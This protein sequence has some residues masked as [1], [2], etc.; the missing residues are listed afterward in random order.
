MY[1]GTELKGPPGLE[2]ARFYAD[3]NALK[4]LARSG[5]TDGAQLRQAAEQF[6]SLFINMMFKTMRQANGVFSEGN[7]FESK[8][9]SFYREMLDNQ[10]SVEMARGGGIGLADL[11]VKQLAGR[12]Q[13]QQASDSG[14]HD[15]EIQPLSDAD[16]SASTQDGFG[17]TLDA[18]RIQA[19]QNAWHNNTQPSADVQ[20]QM[21][22]GDDQSL[23]SPYKPSTNARVPLK[24]PSIETNDGLA[25]DTSVPLLPNV[26][27][28]KT[29]FHTPESFVS[30]V[31]PHAQNAGERLGVDPKVLVA[32]AALETGWGKHIMG[33]G[34]GGSSKNLFGIKANEHRAAAVTHNTLEYVDG[35]PQ[36]ERARFRTYE[37]FTESFNDYVSLLENSP[38]YAGARDQAHSPKAFMV[39]L[40]EAGYATDPKY[41]EKIYRIYQGLDEK[42]AAVNESPEQ[43]GRIREAL[44]PSQVIAS[45]DARHIKR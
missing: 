32:Q 33:D 44:L 34:L 26:Q 4:S 17:R 3:Q 22:Y 6:E 11:L 41:A 10:L 37:S 43:L 9:S 45:T 35:K 24:K 27:A 13:G 15:T 7:L 40:Q 38:R 31:W 20:A 30:A 28:E 23:G 39:A 25:R 14:D 16:I 29:H 2:Q 12:E 5:D 1:N 42:I 21:L 18:F 8:E 36:Q 19:A